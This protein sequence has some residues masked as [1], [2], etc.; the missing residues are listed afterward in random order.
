MIAGRDDRARFNGS[1]D[2][3]RHAPTSELGDQV[4]PRWFVLTAIGTVV[5]AV[6]VGVVALV[7][8]AR[9]DLPV[10]ARRPPP[11]ATYTTDVG[12][13]AAGASPPRAADPPC[14]LLDGIRLAGTAADRE[15]LRA[16]LAGLCDAD[17]PDAVTAD[18]RAFARDGGVVRFATFDATGV[19]S[20]ASR[21]PAEPTILIN[22]R[23]QRT[24]PRWIAPLVAHD[25][26]LR[27]GDPATAESA[28]QARRVEALVCE[29]VLGPDNDSRGC[30]DAAAVTGLD[31]PLAALRAVGFE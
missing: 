2:P 14:E 22:T 12:A 17:L 4:L 28:L 15:Q 6:V 29:R 20:T 11:S 18:L 21:R 19:D 13:V 30:A 23:F 3:W 10:E 26:A 25:V 1:G 16:G 5:V 27:G 31:E 24:N 8:P 7:L 9:R